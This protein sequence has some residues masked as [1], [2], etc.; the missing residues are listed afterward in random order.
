MT[1][2]NLVALQDALTQLRKAL[3]LRM[4]SSTPAQ[5]SALKQV[6]ARLPAAE[7]S[8]PSPRVL[9]EDSPAESSCSKSPADEAIRSGEDSKKRKRSASISELSFKEFLSVD[10]PPYDMI[11]VWVNERNLNFYDCV[12]GGR[13]PGKLI[14]ELRD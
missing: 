2:P 4:A 8:Q 11:R 10:S 3:Q 5:T 13:K 1:D 14:S 12:C 6:L 7:A 9:V